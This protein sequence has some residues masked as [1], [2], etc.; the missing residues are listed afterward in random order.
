MASYVRLSP[1]V[2]KQGVKS[3]NIEMSTEEVLKLR[4][5][6]DSCVLAVNRY[7][8]ASKAGKATGV[9]LSV[10][11]GAT[12]NTVVEVNLKTAVEPD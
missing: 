3:V 5:A 8:R 2:A 7:N 1:D 4:L 10:K 6:L 11:T 12:S 9:C